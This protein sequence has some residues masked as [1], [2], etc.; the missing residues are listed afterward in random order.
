MHAVLRMGNIR[1]T[2]GFSLVKATGGAGQ[3]ERD[4]AV[5][6]SPLSPGARIRIGESVWM[7]VD[8]VFLELEFTRRVF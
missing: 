5:G 2:D 3:S 4:W 7:D 1:E 6:S 8:V